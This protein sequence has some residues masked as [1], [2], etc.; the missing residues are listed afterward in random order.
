MNPFPR[1]DAMVDRI[2]DEYNVC[3]VVTNDRINIG[4]IIM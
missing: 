3:N 4:I 2:H 1:G